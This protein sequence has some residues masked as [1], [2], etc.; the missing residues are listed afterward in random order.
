MCVRPRFGHLLVQPHSTRWEGRVGDGTKGERD[1]RRVEMAGCENQERWN[2][3]TRMTSFMG[4]IGFMMI[5]AFSQRVGLKPFIIDH[6]DCQDEDDEDRTRLMRRCGDNDHHVIFV[7]M[8]FIH[9][10]MS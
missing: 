4:F 10:L 7:I 8:M 2:R 5:H 1:G 3:R 6:S 9:T